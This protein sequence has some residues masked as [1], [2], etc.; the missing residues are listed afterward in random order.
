MDNP[1]DGSANAAELAN[2]L[3]TLNSA[4]D[5]GD[6]WNH[7]TQFMGDHG[8]DVINYAVL[9]TLEFSRAE[10][11][12]TQFSNMSSDWIEHYL[13]QRLDLHDPHV[14][15]AREGGVEPYRWDERRTSFLPS[16][17]DQKMLSLFAEAGLRSQISMV[18]PDP[19]GRGEP[20]GG[21]TIGSSLRDGEYFRAVAG[22]EAMLLS[23]AMLYHNS[24]IGEIR[25]HQVGA[26]PLSP[27]ERDCMTYVASG[28][29][30]ARIAEKMKLSEVTVEM[31]LRNGREKLRARTTAQAVA[32]AMI[33]G[34]IDI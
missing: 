15:Y 27:R 34:D 29:R 19:S 10:A 2:F 9:N 32:R 20:I 11:P 33:F 21:M 18:A 22:K 3:D 5:V 12:V 30:T 31:H 14:R 6:R 25:R 7:L 17:E 13:A 28:L 8:A 23:A 1:D 4:K 16:E 26:R 24:A